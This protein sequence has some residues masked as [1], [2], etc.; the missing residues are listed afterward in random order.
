MKN[1]RKIHV[2]EEFDSEILDERNQIA[3]RLENIANDA[4]TYRS[5]P[6]GFWQGGIPV[7]MAGMTD[8][9]LFGLENGS[10][11]GTH[12]SQDEVDSILGRSGVSVDHLTSTNDVTVRNAINKAVGSAFEI[13]LHD[14]FQN[15]TIHAPVGTSEVQQYGFTH[16]GADFAFLDGHGD[17]IALMNAK[18]SLTYDIIA[19]HFAEHTTVNYVYATHEAAVDAAKHGLHVIDGLHDAVPL[20]DHHVVVDIG[21]SAEEYRRSISQ[22]ASSH[23]HGIFGFFDGHDFLHHVPW[24]T[25]GLVS[26]RALKRNSNG[27]SV[28][29]NQAQVFRDVGR[30]GAAY[31]AAALL[32]HAG[33]P[34][35][36]TMAGTMF[37][38][39]TVQ[40][41]YQV[42]DQ[43]RFLGQYDETLADRLEGTLTPA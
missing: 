13:D 23:E 26:Y 27:I 19:K 40:G 12:L 11:I 36:V 6:V 3:I 37:A 9:A 5:D 33:V 43:W 21:M 17:V 32:Q 24:I 28:K 25:L 34:I 10:D 41:I 39:A 38:S 7:V 15:G 1:R 16:P 2:G 18:A 4:S 8:A 29:D 42:Q 14:G 20:V 30:S 35:P 22:M 31:G